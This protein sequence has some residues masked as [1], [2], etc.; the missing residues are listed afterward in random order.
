MFFLFLHIRN[1]FNLLAQCILAVFGAILIYYGYFEIFIVLAVLSWTLMKND[2]FISAYALLT[3]TAI[4]WCLYYS[5]E[6]TFLVKK[7]EYFYFR[8]HAVIAQLVFNEF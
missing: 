3:L 1:Q 7:F 6:V 5:L 8:Y 2:K 4:L